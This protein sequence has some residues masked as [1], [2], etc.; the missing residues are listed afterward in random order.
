MT[1]SA[2]PNS[3]KYALVSILLS[4]ITMCVLFGG[5]GRE[6]LLA[7][8]VLQAIAG[9]GIAF[10]A[11]SW[12]R[13]ELMG[14]FSTPLIIFMAIGGLGL[15]QILPLPANVWP[16]LP[17][18]SIIVEGYT[19]LDLDLPHSSISLDREATLETISYSLI[20]IFV[21]L[22]CKR[23][24]LKRLS[25][26]V[27]PFFFGLA[28]L[29]TCMGGAQL[30]GGPESTLYLYEFTSGGLPVG[31]FSNVNHQATL[32]LITLP[33]SAD[34][35]NKLKSD[36]RGEDGRIALLIVST[37]GLGV[38]VLGLIATGSIAGYILF[39][40]MIALICVTGP[41]R[42][43][44]AGILAPGPILLF[45]SSIIV[46]SFFASPAADN[47]GLDL[48]QDSGFSRI[49]IWKE[50]ILGVS[51][52]WLL[53]T[54]LGTYESVIPVYEDGSS[55]T[56]VFTAKAHNDF[57][58]VWL[59]GGLIGLLILNWSI[60]WLLWRVFGVFTS[61][62]KCSKKIVQRSACIALLI[63]LAHS[64]VDYPTRT[65][66]IASLVTI[67]VAMIAARDTEQSRQT[68]ET[69]RSAE[70]HKRLVL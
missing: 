41:R 50:T 46:V 43:S 52:H 37:T 45:F 3:P 26:I 7:H 38:I 36:L 6:G 15:I 42:G 30:I 58:Q 49:S 32:L 8:G 31:F 39:V 61:I 24:G 2:R 66:A 68:V 56:S 33:F 44:P 40:L 47:L 28:I 11:I 23:I 18:R 25:E 64:F 17:G 51:D 21:L 48:W 57:L 22:L 35:V 67:C 70:N 60:A 29:A 69:N 54:G 10:L 1:N 13:D 34:L 12:P 59:E 63:V 65:P 62:K 55:V 14:S 19:L 20:P 9:L 53:G 27:P 16:M 5:A 4:Y